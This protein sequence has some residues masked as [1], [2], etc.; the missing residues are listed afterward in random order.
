M[1]YARRIW[2][3]VLELIFPPLCLNCGEYIVKSPYSHRLLCRDCIELI[4]IYET[5]F[6]N[7][8]L[9]L[10]AVSSYGSG[11]LR[12]L[13]H[14][15]KYEGLL[16]A[17]EII[18]GLIRRYMSGV[19]LVGILPKNSV[20]V[21]LPLHKSRFRKR[22][23]NQSEVIAKLLGEQLKLP[24]AKK[25]LSRVKDTPQQSKIKS[26]SGREDNVKGC[27]RV[28]DIEC[29][30]GRTVILVDDVYTS[31]ATMREAAKTL[32]KSGAKKIVGF[33]IALAGL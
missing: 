30:K 18:G 24:V 26:K 9:T 7:P 21:P 32:R 19:D 10:V 31:G 1:E 14:A 23:F 22:G 6:Y 8:K 12:K 25:V 28:K 15:F 33:T 13:L 20:I 3:Y 5:I 29:F 16:G 27:F 4:P 11:P 2:G 17:K